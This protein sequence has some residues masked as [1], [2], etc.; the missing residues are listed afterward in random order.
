M[1]GVFNVNKPAGKTSRQV[2]NHIQR[3]VR[4]AKAGHA[5]TLDP[6]AT[7]VLV[8]CV[9]PATRLIENVQASRKV[10]RATFLLGRSSDTEDV[11]G[12]VVELQDPL[13]PE[14]SAIRAAIPQFV[15][16]IQQRPPA[17]SAL[18]VSG[19]RAYQLARQGQAVILKERP[20]RITRL[21]LLS[22]AYPELSL[23]VE[24]GAGT[25][26]RSLGRDLATRLGTAAVMSQLERTAVGPFELADACL[27]EQLTADSLDEHLRPA[28][29]LFVD[30]PAERLRDSEV[31]R[32]RTGQAVYRPHHERTSD[33]PAVDERGMLVAVLVARGPD[34]LQPKRVLAAPS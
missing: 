15:G 13:R 9:G 27:L 10:Y 19:Q 30:V 8:V 29:E 31:Q 24:C 14:A 33:V 1:F 17:F 26:I 2:V 20:V 4:P 22:Y 23:E 28:T 34:W 12:K 25:Y 18:K 6:L 16:T 7:G 11:E 3:L 21:E 5:G 32:V